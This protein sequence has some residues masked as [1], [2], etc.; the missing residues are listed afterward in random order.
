M[1]KITPDNPKP[2]EDPFEGDPFGDSFTNVKVFIVNPAAPMK[3]S[4][5]IVIYYLQSQIK[6]KFQ[7]FLPPPPSS[8]K[9]HFERQ[10]T[11]TQQTPTS[12]TSSPANVVN[13]K[14]P[15][16][17]GSVHWFDKETE[18]LFNEGEV[19]N[20]AR[21]NSSSDDDKDTVRLLYKSLFI[22]YN[23]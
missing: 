13:N 15:P 8:S 16:P 11:V 6:D 12:D 7:P 3:A 10:Q 18:D 14:T 19:S 4:S 5:L 20:S 22:L 23:Y 9:R 2:S 17:H 1:E 21:K